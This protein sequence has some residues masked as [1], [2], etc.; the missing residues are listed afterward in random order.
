MNFSQFPTDITD[1]LT[2]P[3]SSMDNSYDMGTFGLDA[4]SSVMGEFVEPM[5]DRHVMENNWIGDD[6]VAD[7]LWNMDELWQL[8]QRGNQLEY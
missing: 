2:N 5:G 6:E 1:Y 7:S 8:Q 3:F 4:A